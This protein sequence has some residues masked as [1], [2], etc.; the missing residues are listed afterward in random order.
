MIHNSSM[1]EI[2]FISINVIDQWMC[3]QLILQQASWGSYQASSSFIFQVFITIF[4]RFMT[5]PK[6][7]IG[8][9]RSENK[10]KVKMK[11]IEL[12]MNCVCITLRE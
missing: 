1:I 12:L 3:S 7:H 10:N 11:I 4:F 5:A 6:D 8:A 2:A 9:L